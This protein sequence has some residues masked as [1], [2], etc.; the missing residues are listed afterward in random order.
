MASYGVG[1]VDVTKFGPEIQEY[2]ERIDETLRPYGGRF[3]I[4]GGPYH[5]LEGEWSSGLIVLEFADMATAL[6]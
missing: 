1:I 3:L 2:L 6:S 5:T 4:H